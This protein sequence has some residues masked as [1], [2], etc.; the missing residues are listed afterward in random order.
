[1]RSIFTKYCLAQPSHFIATN[2]G[3]QYGR[4]GPQGPVLLLRHDA[5]ARILANGSA[6]FIESCAAIGWNS[7]D[8]VRSL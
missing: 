6:A 4:L 1:M 5:V 3:V 7:C 8:S 2:A